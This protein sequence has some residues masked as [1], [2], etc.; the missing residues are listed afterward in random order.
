MIVYVSFKIGRRA[1]VRCISP[2]GAADRPIA[3]VSPWRREGR[4]AY[5]LA[6]GLRGSFF[7]TPFPTMAIRAPNLFLCDA[8]LKLLAMRHLA[9]ASHGNEAFQLN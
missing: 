6:R 8:R 2:R 9:A 5:L 4:S 1:A 7:A 3:N